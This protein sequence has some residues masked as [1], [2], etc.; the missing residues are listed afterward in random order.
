MKDGELIL[1]DSIA[2]ETR[3]VFGRERPLWQATAEGTNRAHL[4]FGVRAIGVIAVAALAACGAG[5]G[6]LSHELGDGIACAGNVRSSNSIG[7]GSFTAGW[8][9]T[10]SADRHLVSGGLSHGG[11]D[12][13]RDCLH[14]SGHGE[15]GNG[16]IVVRGNEIDFFSGTLCPLVLPQGVGRYQWS[17]Q[18]AT[19]HLAPLNVDPCGRVDLLTN[20]SYTKS[21]R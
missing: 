9:G 18:G 4:F 11:P 15:Q 13:H 10:G 1:R 2:R 19:L 6:F 17:L 5:A 3:T 7:A 21:R 14:P 20:E 8:P 12:T 16:D